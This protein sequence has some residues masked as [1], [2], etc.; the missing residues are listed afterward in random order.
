[1]RRRSSAFVWLA[2]LLAAFPAFGQQSTGQLSGTV[3]DSDGAPL[4]G[5]TV[6]V[7]SP[8]QIGGPRSVQSE[9]D[10]SFTFPALAPGI[11]TVRIELEGFAPEQHDN[12]QVRLDRSTVIE[13]QLALAAVTE[14][15][16][17][18]AEAEVVDPTQSFTG[19]VF[20]QDYLEE[21]TVGSGGRSYQ[22]VIANTAG[23]TASGGNPIVFGSTTDENVFYID[24]VDTTD[25]VTATFG[26]NFNFDAIQEIS[27]L[28]AGYE[29]EYGRATGGVMNLITKSGGNEL[30]GT[31]DIR[32]RDSDFNENGDHFDRE[33]NPTERLNPSA[34]LGGPI[35]RDEVWYFLSAEHIAT[36]TTPTGSPTTNEFEGQNYLAKLTWQA[37]PEWQVV[38]KVSADPA[39]IPNANAS[40]FRTPGSTRR[41]EQGGEI[42]TADVT[43][44][45]SSSLFLDVQ[46]GI[47]RSYLDSQPMSGDLDTP[48]IQNES[49]GLFSN[50]YENYQFSDRD[51]DELR[52]NLSYF[53]DE[54]GGSHQFKGGVS[55]SDLFFSSQNNLTGGAFYIDRDL[56][57][58]QRPRLLQ[59]SPELAPQ[60][61]NG[62]LIGAFVQ[63]SWHVRPNVTLN[64]GVRYDE[65]AFD[66]DRGSEIASLDKLQPRVGFAWDVGS[67]SRTVVRGSWGRFMHPNALTLPSFARS[68]Q[69][70]TD[71]YFACARIG[72]TSAAECAELGDLFFGHSE[73]I[74]DPLRRDPFGFV[75]AQRTASL[76][77]QVDPG[78]SAM[79]ADS[80]TIGVERQ[81]AERTSVELQYVSKETDD[82]FEDTCDGNFPVVGASDSC[83]FYVMANLRDATRE[84]EG[85]ILR[86]ESRAFDWL[87]L[88]GSYVYSE[89]QGSI[90]DTQNAGVDFDIFP[91]HFANRFGYLSDDRR[92]RVKLNGYVQL[93]LDFSLGFDAFWSSPFAYSVIEAVD[94]YGERYVEPR[95]SRRANESHQLDLEVRKG[96]ALGPL[97]AQVI[98][99]VL[100]VFGEEQATSVCEDVIAGAGGELEAACGAGLEIGDPLT[101]Q[102]PRRYEAGLRF[103]F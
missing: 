40:R 95:G 62:D 85:I 101:F 22:A 89:S 24:G 77:N 23:V 65:V 31:F 54:L 48:G 42:Y 56:G 45:L 44:V 47:V 71:F 87:N 27:F 37:S 30:S 8:S 97:E 5:V 6:T 70:P 100:N 96:F 28:T 3:T 80:W 64:V 74:Q 39:E 67:D 15:L 55:W 50:N 58:V 83:D 2:L 53:V 38:G 25:P 81:V 11:Y 90:E 98:A 41:Q 18:V 7:S 13:A 33:D 66:N 21:A 57:G 79:Y 10:G 78:L 36:E 16:V 72:A 26:T 19:Q 4:P 29:A 14:S 94:P 32:Y 60:E 1:M 49:T 35:R 59:V 43:G 86:V 68:E 63:D 82:I 93:P 73:V 9:A 103:T 76:P 75:L 12:V 34:T 91:L 52:A 51:R 92:H 20:S 99:T 84:Y 88:V 46:A 61:F 17:V 69:A 102:Q